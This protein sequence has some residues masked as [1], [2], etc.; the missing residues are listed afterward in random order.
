M[1]GEQTD[2]PL[3]G[4]PIIADGNGGTILASPIGVCYHRVDSTLDSRGCWNAVDTFYASGVY[5]SFRRGYDA[6]RQARRAERVADARFADRE[7]G[8]VTEDEYRAA[9]EAINAELT[10]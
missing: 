2:G 8:S 7:P 1:L 5:Q 10:L 9:V 3:A 6:Q 4:W